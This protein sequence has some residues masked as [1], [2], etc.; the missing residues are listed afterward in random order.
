MKKYMLLLSGALLLCQSYVTNAAQPTEMQSVVFVLADL[1]N[2]MQGPLKYILT[3]DQR[4]LEPKLL[5]EWNKMINQALNYVRKNNT[6]IFGQEDMAIA[7]AIK[8][9]A[10]I[11]A[12]IMA[13]YKR[14]IDSRSTMNQGLKRQFSD[15]LGNY[16]ANLV[17]IQR[18]LTAG[19]RTASKRN[20]QA[21]LGETIK[22]L[23]V[24]LQSISEK[25]EKMPNIF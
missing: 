16:Y 25:L 19:H 7:L 14:I 23:A 6:N 21:I 20:A 10:T 1:K 12:Q 13:F 22:T 8:S 18:T 11:N 17:N 15:Q 4:Q 3:E 5:S 2:I 9:V 24:V